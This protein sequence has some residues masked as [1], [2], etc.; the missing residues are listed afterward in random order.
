MIG[1]HEKPKKR[2]FNLIIIMEC[3][4]DIPYCFI[5]N[6][7][8]IIHGLYIILKLF[9]I[10]DNHNNHKYDYNPPLIIVRIRSTHCSEIIILRKLLIKR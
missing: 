8:G 4:S 5:T 6:I 10:G 7:L 3:P 2:T 9:T 1:R